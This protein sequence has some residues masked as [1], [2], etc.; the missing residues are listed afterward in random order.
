MQAAYLE[1]IQAR[2]KTARRNLLLLTRMT[3]QNLSYSMLSKQITSG[4]KMVVMNYTGK[5]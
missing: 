4:F 5:N 3:H 1:W 2:G